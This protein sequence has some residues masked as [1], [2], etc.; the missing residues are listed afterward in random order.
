MATIVNNPPP[1]REYREYDRDSSAG[2][3]TGILVVVLVLILIVFVGLPYIRNTGTASPGAPSTGGPSDVNYSTNSSNSYAT[4]TN[5][6]NSSNSANQSNT[7]PPAN[8]NANFNIRA[9]TTSP[10]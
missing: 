10:Y 6:Y 5:Y 8:I 3:L 7:A 2:L 4:S 1:E 9:T